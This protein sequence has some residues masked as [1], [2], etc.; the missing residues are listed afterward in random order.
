VPAQWPGSQTS[1][2]QPAATVADTTVPAAEL[3]WQDYLTDDALQQVITFA[4]AHNRDLRIAL[5]NVELARAQL[6]LRR[7]DQ[8]PTVNASAGGS[9]A[10]NSAGGITSMYSAGL[11]VTAYELDFFDRV[12]NLKDQAL[13]QYL[14]SEE[15]SRT[16]RI[17]L[18]ATVAQTWLTLL[19]DEELLSLSRQALTS[20]DATLALVQLRFQHGAAS[21]LELSIAR[22]LAE[23]A[24]VTL[25]QQQ[26]QR[27]LDENA[28][29]LLM[30]QPLPALLRRQLQPGH[31]TRQQL[32]NLP[33]D[34][35][36]DLLQ[37]RPDIRQAEQLLV[38]SNAGIGA[39][40]AAFFP[41]ISLTTGAGMV[42]NALTGLFSGGS[43]GF[44][45][46]PQLVLPLLDGGRNQAQLDAALTGQ[47]V[48]IAQYDRTVQTAFREVA[49][50][51][52][53]RDVWV[54]QLAAQQAQ[55]DAEADRLRLTD[56][57]LQNGAA[58]LL[59]WLDAERSVFAARQSLVQTRL[60]GLQNQI[61][62]YKALGG[63][64]LVV[65]R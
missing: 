42:S 21:A 28:L 65:G 8:L 18:I 57:R 51:L 36:S 53:S 64:D 35:P 39:A 60:A 37:R 46:A 22:S 48:A 24:R 34:L 2:A 23:S 52:A 11:T 45:F 1:T 63:G 19:A 50:A 47:N 16:A 54:R 7:A 20:R 59:E 31:L 58:S 15:G 55:T 33:A 3:A 56:L 43:W 4:L 38:A 30:G 5:L 14:A 49:D 32:K 17:G 13:A 6:G 62:L 61:T 12:A 40:R 41:R 27:A 26:R 29:T 9:R 44:S 10:P 25:A